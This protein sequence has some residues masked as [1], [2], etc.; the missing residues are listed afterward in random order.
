MKYLFRSYILREVWIW[1]NT[2]FIL[3]SVKTEIARSARGLKLQEPRCRR[4]NGGAV[5]PAGNFGD[6]MTADHK[7][8]RDNLRISKQ[9]SIRS[10]GTGL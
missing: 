7:V 2:V 4:R 9:S 10:R 6:L 8:L 3:I 5:P 1:V